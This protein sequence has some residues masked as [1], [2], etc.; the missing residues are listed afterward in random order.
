MDLTLNISTHLVVDSRAAR[1]AILQ[2]LPADNCI[3][4]DLNLHPRSYFASS[5]PQQVLAFRISE[6][7]HIQ[8]A[9]EEAASWTT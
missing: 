5:G 2:R 9:L 4:P 6:A 3:H 8:Y 7:P 1:P